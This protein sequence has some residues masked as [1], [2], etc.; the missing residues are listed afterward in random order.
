[1]RS[2]SVKT[3]GPTFSLVATETLAGP[4]ANRLAGGCTATNGPSIPHASNSNS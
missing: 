4:T 3:V 1:M 2:S